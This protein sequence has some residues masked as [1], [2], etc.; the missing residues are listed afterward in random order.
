MSTAAGVSCGTLPPTR[1]AGRGGTQPEARSSDRTTRRDIADDVIRRTGARGRGGPRC[2]PRR[3]FDSGSFR[4][5][6]AKHPSGRR[7]IPVFGRASSLRPAGARWERRHEAFAWAFRLSLS[8]PPWWPSAAPMRRRRRA[9]WCPRCSRAARTRNPFSMCGECK[10][11]VGASWTMTTA[12]TDCERTNGTLQPAVACEVPAALG[13]CMIRGAMP[14]AT[15]IT[16][17]GSDASQCAI[18]QTGCTVF[19]R[20]EF[21]PAGVCAAGGNGGVTGDAGATDAAT[22]TDASTSAAEGV[23]PAHADVPRATSGRCPRATALAVRCA[24]GTPSPPPPRSRRRY[25]D[26]ASCEHVRTQRPYYPVPS[27]AT[28]STPDTCMQDATYVVV[29]STGCVGRWSRAR[30]CAATPSAWRRRGASNWYVEALGNWT[31]GFDASGLALGADLDRLHLLRRLSPRCRTKASRGR[32]RA[33]P[34]TDPARMRDFFER[35]LMHR[36]F[37]PRGLRAHRDPSA[38]R[39]T[40]NRSYQPTACAE[41]RGVDADGT[42]RW[43]SAA[44]RATCTCSMRASANPRRS[45]RTS[46]LPRGTRWRVDVAPTSSPVVSGIKYGRVPNGATQRFPETGAPAPLQPG[47]MYYLYVLLD[48][49]GAPHALPL[50]DAA[51]IHGV[52]GVPADYASPR[53]LRSGRGWPSAMRS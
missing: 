20:G 11:Y 52:G 38:D 4:G 10:D 9:S 23:S 40:A 6:R 35:E 42:V 22:T 15:R 51:V 19:A 24:P 31:N 34:S 17:P 8:S 50:H 13:R 47:A 26:Y 30:A 27:A 49:G 5:G 21:V 39:S 3:S 32:C 37:Y 2:R 16:F 14:D 12:T 25:D 18:T 48:V 36:G 45:T 46:T 53:T 7:V 41:G 44:L 28:P 33:L 29:S 43:G 1:T